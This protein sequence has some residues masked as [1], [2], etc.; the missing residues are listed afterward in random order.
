MSLAPALPQPSRTSLV[1]STIAV[2][3][4]Q[5]EGGDWPLGGRI[6]KEAELA[7]LLKVGRN[8]VREAV[9]VLSHAG[10]LEVRQGD[11]TYVR[12]KVDPSEIM[13]RVTRS[14]LRDHFEARAMLDTEAA[15]LA[16]LR[17]SEADLA[18]LRETLAARGEGPVGDD[19]LGF[20]Q[21]DLAFHAAIVAAAHN[22]ALSELYYYF[23]EA[24]RIH[25]EA[26]ACERDEQDASF[27]LHAR[28]VDAIAARAPEEAAAA[29]RAIVTPTVTRLTR[30][31]GD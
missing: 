12:S 3:R 13:R 9:R 20:V 18:L 10:V 22:E 16:A 24:L 23:T 2:I 28:I 8:T 26:V 30:L 19:I 7:E 11:G 6:P 14:S 15:R 4:T 29:A 27:A 17:R 1:E 5:I 25:R 21:R 31:M